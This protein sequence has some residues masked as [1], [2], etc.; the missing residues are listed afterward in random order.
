M[1]LNIESLV[2]ETYEILKM[3][4]EAEEGSIMESGSRG[5][6]DVEKDTYPRTEDRAYV[7]AEGEGVE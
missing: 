5:S 4:V 7:E 3:N 2:R 6:E 1:E